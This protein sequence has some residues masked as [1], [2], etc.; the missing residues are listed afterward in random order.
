MCMESKLCALVTEYYI[1]HKLHCR[2]PSFKYG[3][4][5]YP[6]QLDLPWAQFHAKFVKQKL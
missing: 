3:Q 2:A 4:I 6:D 5:T 1:K